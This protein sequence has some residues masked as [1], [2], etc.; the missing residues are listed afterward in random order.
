MKTESR[1]KDD[2]QERLQSPK[3]TDIID[4]LT[5]TSTL[6]ID[7][8]VSEFSDLFNEVGYAKFE[9]MLR[10]VVFGIMKQKYLDVDVPS[11]F[12]DIKIKPVFDKILMH[13]INAK[14]ENTLVN[15]DCL[16]LAGDVAKTYI[17]E[18]KLICPKCEYGFAVTCDYNRNLPLEFCPNPSC[19]S[20]KLIADPDTLVTEYIQTLFLQE[21]LDEARHNSPIMFVGKI[22][23]NAVRTA[24]P[25][26]R[27]KISGFF[28]TVYDSKKVEQDNI[29]DVAHLEDLDDVKL[30]KPTKEELKKLKDEAKKPDFLN[31]VIKSYAPH[32][33]GYLEIKESLLLQLAGGVNGKRRGDINTL[34]VGDP[35]MAKSE[36]LKFGKKITQ[37]SIYTSGK[38]TSAAGLT[39]GM[40]KL[41]DGTMI[42][43]AG[44]LPLCSGGFAFIDEFDKMNKL[45]RSSMHEAMEQQTVSRAVAGTNITLPAKTSILAAANPKFGKYDPT[46]SLGENINVPPALLSRFDL[47]W[48]IKD[49]VDARIDLAKASHI[50][51]SYSDDRKIEKPFLNTRELMSYVNYIREQKPKLSPQTRREILKIYEKMRTLSKEDESALAIGTRQ[52]EALI[53][54]SLAHAKLLF[55]DEADVEDVHAVKEILVD[56]FKTFGLDMDEGKFDQTLMTGVTGKETKEQVANRI[57]AEVSDANGDVMLPKFMFQ[58]ALADEFDESS[59]KKVFDRWDTNCLVRMNTNGTW[60]KKL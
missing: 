38:G 42:A 20:A 31:R 10:D 25:G 17:K 58:L 45:D 28:K 51:D 14:H 9:T 29:I 1:M 52:L 27:K 23:G 8:R 37:T 57:W 48:L 22:K 41:S 47:I 21:P 18:C 26:Q 53:R 24:F 16:I 11:T 2:L 60:R 5:P 50:L 13:D 56:M 15:F 44:V 43:Q 19:R 46:V 33:Y 30:L 34:L 6:T 55:K 49:K 12:A 32:I 3:W 54:L 4:T 7:L 40:V 59:A 39:I 36:L 35:S